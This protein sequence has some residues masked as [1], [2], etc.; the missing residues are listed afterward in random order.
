VLELSS[1][2]LADGLPGRSQNQNFGAGLYGFAKRNRTRTRSSGDVIRPNRV[3][4]TRG[5][6]I[7]TGFT[8][9]HSGIRLQSLPSSACRPPTRMHSSGRFGLS[10]VE[11]ANYMH[12]N[13]F[14]RTA[15]AYRID[16]L[17]KN[18]R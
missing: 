14:Y 8:F 12:R 5:V 18:E 4:P 10:G 17:R 6:T 11:K 9:R 13:N 16:C 2:Q 15:A 3:K 7:E 1:T